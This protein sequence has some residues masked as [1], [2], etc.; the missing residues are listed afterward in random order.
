MTSALPANLFYALR[1]SGTLDIHI[2]PAG[3]GFTA[4]VT[5]DTREHVGSDD[6]D[7]ATA[8]QRALLMIGMDE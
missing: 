4:T 3:S 7:P 8:L 2:E 5:T 6:T 1:Q